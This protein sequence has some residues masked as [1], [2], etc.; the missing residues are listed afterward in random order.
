M[1]PHSS[2]LLQPLDVGCFS[3]LKRAYG[4][5]VEIC[6]QLEHN[7]IDK[8]DFLET[9]KP[10][11]AAALSASNI[12]SGFAAAGLVPHNSERVLSHLQFKLRTPTPPASETAI[13]ACQT[14]K[15]SY[16][17]AQLAQE[18]TTI[19]GLLKRRSKSPPSPMEQ[20]LKRVVKGCQMAM[21]NTA[22]LA[23]EIKDLRVMSAR[24]KRKRETPCSYI[25]SGGVLTAEE[26]QERAKR[27]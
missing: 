12:H 16:T 11:R 27:A 25:A 17:V 19:K 18:Y 9:F 22:L 1:P 26:G 23:S 15:T 24:Q 14:P 10:A 13:A 5:Q 7:H 3:P 2:H 20:T 6:M 8:L 4:H 21:H